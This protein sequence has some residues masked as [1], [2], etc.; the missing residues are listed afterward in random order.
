VIAE[1]IHR[2]VPPKFVAALKSFLKVVSEI[3]G[4]QYLFLGFLKCTFLLPN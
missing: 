1:N 4:T 2:A 3:L